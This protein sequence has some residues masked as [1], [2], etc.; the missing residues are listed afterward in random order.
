M[1][2]DFARSLLSM[3]LSAEFNL[4]QRCSVRTPDDAPACRSAVV[5]LHTHLDK[6]RQCSLL[7]EV[8]SAHTAPF[9][10]H[11]LVTDSK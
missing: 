9:H 10:Q 4:P 8:H 1:G 5:W 11:V 6:I 2:S 7:V 3:E